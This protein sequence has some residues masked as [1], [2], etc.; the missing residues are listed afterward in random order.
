MA[1][2]DKRINDP[3]A[4][5]PFFRA[6]RLGPLVSEFLSP[7]RQ[8]EKIRNL[9]VPDETVSEQLIGTELPPALSDMLQGRKDKEE[10]L[11]RLRESPQVGEG[12]RKGDLRDK[13]LFKTDPRLADINRLRGTGAQKGPRDIGALERGVKGQEGELSPKTKTA[14][15]QG[16]ETPIK[17]EP[18][19]NVDSKTS[20][21]AADIV[22]SGLS[23]IDKGTKNPKEVAEQYTKEIMDL[24]PEFE[25]KSKQEKGL[26][27]AKLGMA[28]AAGESPN[29][30]Q[31][32]SKGFL[33]MGDTFTEDAKE[34]RAFNLQMKT[35]AAKYT[36]DRIAEDRG[37]AKDFEYFYNQDGDMEVLSKAEIARGKRPSEGFVTVDAAK[38]INDGAIAANQLAIEQAAKLE[39]TETERKAYI[40][41]YSQNIDLKRKATLGQE[42]TTGLIESLEK[43]G[44]NKVFGVTGAVTNL[45]E[46]ARNVFGI[47]VENY[48]KGD[49]GKLT[50]ASREQFTSDLRK[51]FQLMIPL[52]LGKAQSANSISDRDVDI[53]A[54][55]AVA[56]ILNEDAAFGEFFTTNAA[57]L[58]TKLRS[59][60]DLFR[61]TNRDATARLESLDRRFGSR[62]TTDATGTRRASYLVEPFK[63]SNPGVL[64][65]EQFTQNFQSPIGNVT[66]AQITGLSDEVIE[67]LPQYLQQRARQLQNAK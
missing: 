24:L 63:E 10:I 27:L 20:K 5:V 67:Q 34:R 26:D 29:A 15:Q 3:N 6:S 49:D 11:S 21:K 57:V 13:D 55:A 33:A 44:D 53:F 4:S 40:D 28:I 65:Y 52:S 39:L 46:Q 60:Y 22:T 38:I 2:D 50:P 25:G 19:V 14:L 41:G 8:I 45:A 48:E 7:R 56:N 17:T 47:S 64:T 59:A 66:D 62:Q 30:I 23:D 16:S 61:D 1:I 18:T 36:L 58:E 42:L 43:G 37:D 32:I 35:L 31:N 9:G 54:K 12:I 51:V